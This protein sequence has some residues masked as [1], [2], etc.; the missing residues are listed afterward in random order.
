M[1][2]YGTDALKL[3]MRWAALPDTTPTRTPGLP[4]AKPDSLTDSLG[5]PSSSSDSRPVAV[6]SPRRRK[7]FPR[8]GLAT[9]AEASERFRK[10]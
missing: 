10:K 2:G 7:N 5:T 4:V 8:A 1:A 9:F 6:A 3:S